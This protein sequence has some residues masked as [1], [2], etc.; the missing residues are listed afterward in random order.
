VPDPLWRIHV[1]RNLKA[2]SRA[3][4]EATREQAVPHAPAGG[5]MRAAARTLYQTGVHLALQ[6]CV[7][8][9]GQVVIDRAIG[10]A[11]G[12]G[13]QDRPDT[14]KEPVT[15]DTPCCVFSTSKGITALVVHPCRT[16]ASWT[17]PTG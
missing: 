12:N 9:H 13:P 2:I 6:L 16:E 11:R 17:S 5:R 14:P 15:P 3:G 8:H 10:H 4:E 7:R 1:P